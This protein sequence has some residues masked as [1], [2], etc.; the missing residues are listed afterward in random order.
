VFFYIAWA[1][2]SLPYIQRA[3]ECLRAPLFPKCVISIIAPIDHMIHRAG[4]LDSQFVWHGRIFLSFPFRASPK[5][6]KT[7]PGVRTNVVGVVTND[8]GER[9]KRVPKGLN[10]FTSEAKLPAITVG[11]GAARRNPRI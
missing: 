7:R 5:N 10:M 6:D 2:A 3:H 1:V 8:A 4:V 11:A 9:C